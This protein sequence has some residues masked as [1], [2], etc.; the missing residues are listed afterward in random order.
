MQEAPERGAF[1]ALTQITVTAVVL[2]G[3]LAALLS[4]LYLSG[5]SIVPLLIGI[6]LTTFLAALATVKIPKRMA[7]ERRA[8]AFVAGVLFLC[9]G[10]PISTRWPGGITGSAY[11]VTVVGICPVP[12]FDVTFD[13]RGA[14]GF[15][16]KTH[17]VKIEEALPLAKDADYL[18]VG[19]GWDGLVQVDEEVRGIPGVKVEVLKTPDAFKRYSQLRREGKRVALIAHSTC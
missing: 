12:L 17:R 11:G 10:L 1:K 7:H 8:V 15:R 5:H 2:L 16:D 3:L 6:A 4:C 13:G 19:I 18:I 9:V 14:M